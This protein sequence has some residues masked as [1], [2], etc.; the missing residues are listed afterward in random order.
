[1]CQGFIDKRG[2]RCGCPAYSWYRRHLGLVPKDLREASCN[3]P[4][5]PSS[6]RR[7]ISAALTWLTVL[8]SPWA[9][10]APT[11]NP[12]PTTHH[13]RQQPLQHRQ[14]ALQLQQRPAGRGLAGQ[15]GQRLHRR[16]NGRRGMGGRK[17]GC[18]T[19]MGTTGK[20]LGFRST[21]HACS[22]ACMR[23]YD[24]FATH[25]YMYQSKTL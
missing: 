25:E 3:T 9:P 21:E 20:A 22:V 7:H 16:D 13:C 23:L 2:H 6:R 10:P 8:P 11:T 15:V 12:P 4:D 18:G 24:A 5:T 1:M 17:K 19:A 14:V